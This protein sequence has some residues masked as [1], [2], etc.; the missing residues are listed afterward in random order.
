MKFHRRLYSLLNLFNRHQMR[1]GTNHA[2]NL[3]SVVMHDRPVRI[4]PDR[5]P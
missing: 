2:A 1:D 3:R 5:A 4:V